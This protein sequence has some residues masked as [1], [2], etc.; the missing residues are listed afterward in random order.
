MDPS[1]LLPCCLSCPEC[2][3]LGSPTLTDRFPMILIKFD[4][5]LSI[6]NVS[7]S[8]TFPWQQESH[9]MDVCRMSYVQN[10]ETCQCSLI[11]SANAAPT[12][13]KRMSSI[14][15]DFENVFNI[16]NVNLSIIC[17]WPQE[18]H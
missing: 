6:W 13:T 16:R 1:H 10:T 18:S 2:P 5:V 17:S 12:C 4:E 15:I 7:L 11:F 14:M 9:E 8:I 3:A